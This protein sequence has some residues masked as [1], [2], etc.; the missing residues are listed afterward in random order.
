MI[1]VKVASRVA[2]SVL[3]GSIRSIY[4]SGR[5]FGVADWRNS[6]GRL[7]RLDNTSFSLSFFFHI[8]SSCFLAVWLPS[9]S[10]SQPAATEPAL[11]PK[12]CSCDRM[13]D[14]YASVVRIVVCSPG[15]SGVFS[16]LIIAYPRWIEA[17]AKLK[18]WIKKR[19]WAMFTKIREVRQF[20]MNCIC[21]QWLA[22]VGRFGRRE[23]CVTRL[24][25]VYF[26]ENN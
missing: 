17:I 26:W 1:F 22:Y 6:N 18:L 19:K 14:E 21:T 9:L 4:N 24:V 23:R 10:F 12:G 7:V 15:M 5:Q 25:Y 16:I 11:A 13:I 3:Y 20:F 2:F 8:R